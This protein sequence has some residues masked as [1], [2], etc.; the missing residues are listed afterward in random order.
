VSGGVIY[1]ESRTRTRTMAE[2]ITGGDSNVGRHAIAAYGCG[3]CHVIPG[4]VG[5]NGA[6]GPSLAGIAT[7]AEI[8][9][10]LPN[11]PQAMQRWL[12]HPQRIAAGNGM[13]EQGIT[14]AEA[15]DMA[16]YLYTLK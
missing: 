5:A 14:Q 2:Q 7:R 8:A 13:P 3:S 9:G 11:D 1:A 4:V 10:H 6:V 16:A 15:R 12:I